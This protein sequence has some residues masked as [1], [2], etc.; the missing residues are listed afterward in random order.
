MRQA[1][2]HHTVLYFR[3]LDFRKPYW[4]SGF[5]QCYA[6]KPCEPSGSNSERISSISHE[7]HFDIVELEKRPEITL[8]QPESGFNRLSGAYPAPTRQIILKFI[9]GE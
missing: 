7:V 1:T 9:T 8:L 3:V 5:V 4:E 2:I 6:R